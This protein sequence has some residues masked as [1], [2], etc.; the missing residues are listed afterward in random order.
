MRPHVKIQVELQHVRAA[1]A[2]FA[3]ERE[4]Q[5]MKDVGHLR[6]G[7]R[8]MH[9]KLKTPLFPNVCRR[10]PHQL[11]GHLPLIFQ[12]CRDTQPQEVGSLVLVPGHGDGG[13]D[14]TVGFGHPD[15]VP[16]RQGHVGHSLHDGFAIGVGMAIGLAVAVE[17]EDDRPIKRAI[18]PYLDVDGRFLG[19]HLSA[20]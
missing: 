16:T 14:L 20:F 5:A 1:D 19:H 15:V 6:R 8:G 17:P 12:V 11:F 10:C 2:T 18:G 7:E 9:D 4:A 3:G 13:D